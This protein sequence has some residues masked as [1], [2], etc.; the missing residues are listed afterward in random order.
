M[1]F[2]TDLAIILIAAGVFTVIS[3]ALKQPVILGYIIAGFLVGPHLGL[4]P[5]SSADAVYQWSEIGIIF[6]LFALGLEFSFKKL[7]K[8]GSSAL[9]TAG[10]KCIGMFAVGL[11]V[12]SLMH[13]TMMESIF[14]G[15]LL[16]MS[17]TT[18]IIKAYDDM[19]LK[20]RPHSTLLFGS[21]VFEDLI[22]VLLMVLLSTLATSNKFAG[23][24]MLI[25]LAKLG[26]FLILWFLVGIYLIP[27]FLKWAHKYLNDEII[28]IIAI[29]LCFL[30]V[31]L[32]EVAG[33][34]SALGAFVI[35]S[36]L[37]ETIEGERIEHSIGSIKDLFGAIFFVS[38]GMMVDPVI[39]G[40][41]W[42]PILILTFVAVLG[43]LVFSTLGALLTG[44]GLKNSVHIGFSLAQLGEFAFI[45]AGLGCA[46]GVMR[47]FIY[48][49][50]V[51]VSVITTFT[52][53]YMI[54]AADPVSDWLYRILPP[55]VI[56]ILDPKT[57]DKKD[58]TAAKNEW[59]HLLKT[60]FLRVLLFGVLLLAVILFSKNFLPSF[61]D[62]INPQ[63]IGT[64]NSW[65][66]F[67]IT[68][69][70]MAPFIYGLT[71]NSKAELTSASLLIES[72]RH[73][74]WLIR[75]LVSIKYFLAVVFLIVLLTTTFK[76]VSIGVFLIA[77]VI[78]VLAILLARKSNYKITI[79]E[80]QFIANFNEKERI[81]RKLRP[82]TTSLED[83]LAGYNVQLA[84]VEIKPNFAFVGKTLREMPFRHIS[85]V[86]IVELMRGNQCIRVPRGSE[87]IYP[88]DIL[89]AVGTNEQLTSFQNIIAENTPVEE[90]INI[91]QF[92]VRI[93]NV[94]EKSPL[95]NK[96]L[97]ESD[98]R[99]YGCLVVS[100]LR[101]G[102]LITNP[103]P[104]ERIQ[105]G[106]RVWVAGEKES[107]DWFDKSIEN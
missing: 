93:I 16:S 38:V 5:I 23:V 84:T 27:L 49:V 19:G 54:K 61:M 25:S 42:L 36:I 8:V 94:N 103:T 89:L 22:A 34:S 51:A 96:T 56:N 2:V 76:N 13:W 18:I 69:I 50:V 59:K 12:G 60:Y 48:P 35:G 86:N 71:V 70:I 82:V 78:M 26:F 10:V 41:H 72:N 30:M 39:I 14:L 24:E 102:K 15:G 79:I 31:A 65:I 9:V 55:K 20:G 83:K 52:T 90:N 3:K 67:G 85:G 32:A 47:E 66:V 101:E 28:V 88:N 4:V 64:I 106:D 58:S 97:R 62:K 11:L 1:N 80:D 95:C 6:L 21:L 53:P 68:F 81:A 100:I 107:C 63:G 104:E 17:S 29:G 87:P 99:A 98:L 92:E 40:Q 44:Q 75:A 91:P 77:V 37:A 43:I 7:L 46:M 57:E 105:D 73:N 33:F 45:I 74:K